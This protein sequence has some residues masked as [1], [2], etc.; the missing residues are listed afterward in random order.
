MNVPQSQGSQEERT[1]PRLLIATFIFLS[2]VATANAEPVKAWESTLDLPTYPW[3]DD[4]NPV[5]Q[6]YEGR[7]YYPYTRQDHLLD[8]KEMRT[9]RALYLEN[10]YLKITCLPELGGRIHSVWDKTT[11]EEMFHNPGVIKPALIAMR[12]AWIAGGIE[13]NV[14]PQGHTVTI[15]SPVDAT[16]VTNDDGSATLVI[17]NTEK[18]FRTRWTVRLTLHPGKAYLDESIRMFNPTD[19]THTYYFW[20][21]TAFPN[22]DGT[23]FIYPMSLGSDHNGEVFFNWP[24]N[25][26]VDMTWLKNYPTMSSVFAYGCDQDFFGAY[27]V[28]LDRGIVSHANHHIVQGKKAWTWGEADFGVM[29]QMA[30]TDGTR[31]EAPYIEVQTGPLL[32]QADYGFLKPH[33]SVSWREYWYPVHGL[34]DGFEFANRDVAVNAKRN[35][36]SLSLAIIATAE[37][38]GARLRV[39]QGGQSLHDEKADLT[40]RAAHT[41]AVRDVTEGPANI[42]IVDGAG[43]TLLA[44]ATPLAVTPVDAPDLEGEAAWRKTLP[45]A[46]Q[47]FMAADLL[48]RKNNPEAARKKY[49]EVVAI[50]PGHVDALNALATLLVEWGDYEGAITRAREALRVDEE[51]SDAWYLLGAAQLASSQL[52]DAIVSGYKVVQ[53][54][55]GVA[56]GYSLV[57][58]AKMLQGGFSDAVDA[59][60]DAHRLD[61]ENSRYRNWWLAARLKSGDGITSE[62]EALRTHGDPTDF[63]VHALTAVA[64]EYAA[65]SAMAFWQKSCGENAFTL[66]EVVT[67]FT[68]LGLYE[69]A[70]TT[71]QGIADSGFLKDGYGPIPYAYLAWCHAQSGDDAMARAALGKIDELSASLE[72]PSRPETRPVLAHAA[73]LA[74]KNAT[75]RTTQGLLEAGLYNAKGAVEHFEAAVKLG[76]GSIPLRVLGLEAWKTKKDFVAAAGYYRMAIAASPNDQ[77]LYRDLSQILTAD[78]KKGEAITLLEGMPESVPARFDVVLW[79]ARAYVDEGR[80]DDCLALLENSTFTNFE[81]STR[82]HDIFEDAL[83]G[84]GKAFFASGDYD[85]ALADFT[86]ALT[87][88]DYLEVGARYVLTDAE[89]RYWQGKTFAKLGR[90]DEARKAWEVG[91]AQPSKDMP[92]QVFIGVNAAQDSHVKKCATAL[93]LLG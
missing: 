11:N 12:G 27:D 81:G 29:S 16:I 54:S 79:R 63:V 85:K 14:G 91:A 19:G 58:R 64:D 89:V 80:F 42:E 8:M 18:M 5:F 44:Y 61:P 72:F 40:P 15:V 69:E 4:P 17:G 84:R 43:D 83:L 88:P 41:V 46:T 71:L 6:E 33:E 73:K 48:D 60:F 87:Y 90:V 57:G 56:R 51:S 3:L 2:I 65:E 52:D 75:I 70:A 93:E 92:K 24:V 32:T 37:F 10:E 78:G 38:P 59:F 76:G 30:L 77:I 34:G 35:G 39:S 50:A 82:P 53:G 86:E 66:I 22:L 23:R 45:E 68:N 25:D 74:P 7:I 21:N 20:N 9:Y 1:M 49:E 13:W 47:L 31:E 26:G 67:F 28:D 55:E 36:G 62:L